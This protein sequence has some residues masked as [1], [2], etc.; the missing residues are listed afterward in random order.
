M[1]FASPRP[2]IVAVLEVGR[3][4]VK[5][6]AI[7]PTGEILSSRQAP[8]AVSS[9]EPYPH[10]DTEHL[11]RWMMAALA[12]LGERFAIMAI[13]P[14]SY[15]STA[16]LIGVDDLVLPILDDETNPP[17]E[18]AAAYAE[19]APWFEECCCPIAP[20]GLTLGRQLFWQSR[21]F[22]EEFAARAGSC[23]SRS[24]GRGG[25]AGCRPARSPP[26]AP[27]PSSGTCASA[28]SRAWSGARA[29]ATGFRRCAMPG[30]W[31]GPCSPRSPTRP[32]CPSRRRCCAES[33][34]AALT[35]PAMSRPG[36]TSSSRSR[37]AAG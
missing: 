36:S 16:A 22:A 7:A 29:G 23:P 12:D 2:A 21:A 15:G 1:A 26:S 3:I 35:S 11:W 28:I 19:I 14:T 17:P 30:T 20:A 8:N 32:A 9:G 27:R 4:D 34:P 13:V 10:C 33:M 5:L 6:L 18:I 31:L 37:P 24:T 25:S